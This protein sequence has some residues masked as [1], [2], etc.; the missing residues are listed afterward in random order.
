MSTVFN[1]RLSFTGNMFVYTSNFGNRIV[2]Q[3]AGFVWSQTLKSWVTT[4]TSIAARLKEH[5]DESALA[6]LEKRKIL[7]VTDA[8]ET[9]WPAH[10]QPLPHQLE[11]VKWATS[12][13]K[14]LLRHDPG[15]GKTIEAA[16]CMNAIPGRVLIICPPFLKINWKREIEK[17]TV[18]KRTVSII[19]SGSLKAVDLSADVLIVPDSLVI[20]PAVANAIKAHSFT[21]CFVDEPQRYK[22][23]TTQRTASVF[24]R[25]LE[26]K[27]FKGLIDLAQRVC[28]LTGTPMP[29]RPI[30]LWPMLISCAPEVIDF[31]N[32][33]EYAKEYCGAYFDGYGW[34]LNGASRQE[35]LHAKLS[36]NFMHTIKKDVLGLQPKLVELV[37]VPDSVLGKKAKCFE[38]ELMKENSLEDLATN[39]LG[40]MAGHR[41][42]L[43]L[44]KIDFAIQF[45]KDIIESTD[46]SVIVFAWHKEVIGRFAEDM[47]EFQ[48]FV[49]TGDTEQKKRQEYV[50]EFQN[51]SARRLFVGNIQAMGVGLTLTKASRIIFIE[52]SWTPS[53]NAQAEDR[54]HR[55]GQTRTVLAQYLVVNDSL[56]EWMLESLQAKQKNIDRIIG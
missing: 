38:D 9:K 18:P 4:Y 3:Q 56:D 19:E 6:E 28:L 17:W 52:Y 53:D 7:V 50:D 29:A 8:P 26:N 30:E 21:W 15:T 22:T 49:I 35:I 27:R 43:G 1:M 34:V 44:A 10:L 40:K 16:L 5:A 13:K 41:K 32:R 2:A 36:E 14:S 33:F 31:K 12:R 20:R 24:G 46:E 45:V 39:A 42:E 51:N 47:K 25:V 11:G 54:A 55:I 48:P 23:P 37:R